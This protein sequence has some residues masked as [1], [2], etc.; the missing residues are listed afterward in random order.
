MACGTVDA[1]VVM[2]WDVRAAFQGVD[3]VIMMA[4]VDRKADDDR[5]E[6]LKNVLTISRQHAAAID[7]FANKT[8]KVYG[9]LMGR[10]GTSSVPS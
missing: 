5:Q 9:L 7:K 3:L 10:S 4:K 2:T 6:Y 8:V 1:E